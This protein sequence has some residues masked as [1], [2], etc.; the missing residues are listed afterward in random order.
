MRPSPRL[1]LI[2]LGVTLLTLIAVLSARDPTAFVGLL[3]VGVIAAMLYD[4]AFTP[5]GHAVNIKA[6]WPRELF[7]GH[8]TDIGIAVFSDHAEVPADIEMRLDADHMIGASAPRHLAEAEIGRYFALTL[9]PRA[10]GSV[11]IKAVILRWR[12]RLGLFEIITRKAV[13]QSVAVIPNIQPVLS[14]QITTKVMAELYG[15]KDV[16]AR[17][18][19]SEFHQLREFQQGMDLRSV[20]WKRSA[21]HHKLMAREMHAE[22]NHQIILALDNG[23]L[24]REEISDLP[25]IDWAIN[26]ALSLAWAAGLGNDKVG[27]YAFDSRPRIYTAPLPGRQAFAR[28][29]SVAAGLAYQSV[30]SNPTLALTHLNSKLNRRSL[31]VVISDFADSTTAELLVEN[32]SVLSRHHLVLFVALR[33]PLLERLRHPQEPDRDDVAMAVSAAQLHK[34][35]Q[36]V[37]DRLERLGII[38]LDCAPSELS[39]ALVSAYIDIKLRERI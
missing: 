8:E 26:A 3:W 34:E 37:L 23:H 31:I 10:R 15:V 2:A 6:E 32:V 20:D 30:E 33:D 38:C 24:M 13:D 5:K 11:Q 7:V 27:F 39:A 29:R 17:G 12:S 14:G 35:R 9:L 36:I 16:L 22:R 4:R 18:E 21:R 19:G 28:L 1:L 25:K